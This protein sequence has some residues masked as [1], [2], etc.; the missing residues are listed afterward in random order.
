MAATFYLIIIIVTPPPLLNFLG[1]LSG[2]FIQI[3]FIQLVLFVHNFHYY[4]FQKDYYHHH[5]T[6]IFA[7]FVVVSH[8]IYLFTCLNKWW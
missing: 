7:Y 8:Y 2:T 6:R 5:P 4:C 3:F 1:S